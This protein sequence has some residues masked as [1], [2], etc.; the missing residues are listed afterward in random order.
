MSHA[1]FLMH[2]QFNSD[3]DYA[4]SFPLITFVEFLFWVIKNF[5]SALFEKIDKVAAIQETKVC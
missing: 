2:V 4:E 5:K 1:A 3:Y